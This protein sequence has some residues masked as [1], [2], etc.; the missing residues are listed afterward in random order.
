MLSARL[1]EETGRCV[2]HQNKTVFMPFSHTQQK[3]TRNIKKKGRQG[4]SR[5]SRIPDVLFGRPI[6]A[7]K[8]SE[9]GRI[10]GVQE[11]PVPVILAAACGTWEGVW[12]QHHPVPVGDAHPTHDPFCLPQDAGCCGDPLPACPQAGPRC[13]EF[14]LKWLFL[15]SCPWAGGRGKSPESSEA[16]YSVPVTQCWKGNPA[17]VTATTTVGLARPLTCANL[18]CI[19]WYVLQESQIQLSRNGRM[20]Q[21]LTKQ[22]ASFPSL[23]NVVF[24]VCSDTLL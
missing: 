3:Y 19:L 23:G 7:V 1:G 5:S 10:T 8:D 9:H 22:S 21:W 20:S 17:R 11:L 14:A 24:L 18:F 16:G 12:V 4:N 2:K 6:H 13:Q 15:P